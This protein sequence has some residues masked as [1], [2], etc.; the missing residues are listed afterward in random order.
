MKNLLLLKCKRNLLFH[1]SFILLFSLLIIP[2]SN[3][4]DDESDEETEDTQATEVTIPESVVQKGPFVSGSAITI[5]ILDKEFNPTG[6][7]LSVQT[8]ND[9]GEFKVGSKI[10]SN[11]VEVVAK[12]YYFNE[13]SGKLSD[14]ELTLRSVLDLSEAKKMNINVLTSLTKDRIVYLVIEED[15][16]FSKAKKQAEQELLKAFNIPTDNVDSFESM[17][18]SQAGESNAILLALSATL[19]AENSVA[20]LSELISK[21]N[22][23]LEK[24][25]I[26][27]NASTK[28][29]WQVNS[30]LFTQARMA[31]VRSNIA[32]RY[33]NLGLEVSIPNFEDYMD[34]DGD[35]KINKYDTFLSFNISESYISNEVTIGMMPNTTSDT[36]SIDYGSIVLN[37]TDTGQKSISVKQG[38]KVA[39]KISEN[40][41]SDKINITLD[42]N[43]GIINLTWKS[44]TFNGNGNT[45]GSIP[46]IINCIQGSTFTAPGNTG[47]L[48]KA[49]YSFTGWNTSANG[50]GTTYTQGQ[51]FKIGTSGIT[52]YA[53]WASA[54][55]TLITAS[56]GDIGIFMDT[57]NF[58]W[59]EHNPS[60]TFPSYI[61]KAPI[62][63]GIG[64][65]LA[66]G[67]DFVYYVRLIYS[68]KI[69]YTTS[70]TNNIYTIPTIGG[71][72]SSIVTY[73]GIGSVGKMLTDGTYI[74]FQGN[75]SI[76]KTSITGGSYSTL[77]DSGNFSGMVID[78]SNIY[79]FYG[80]SGSGVVAK[81]SKSGGSPT[82]LASGLEQPCSIT[83]DSLYIYWTDVSNIGDM[84]LKKVSKSGGSVTTMASFSREVP[85]IASHLM[86]VQY[87]S[88]YIYFLVRVDNASSSS[89]KRVS[90]ISPYEVSAVVVGISRPAG[91]AIDSSYIYWAS[92]WNWTI[93]KIS[94]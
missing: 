82:I 31:T 86:S 18:I 29:Q 9:L 35:G 59:E 45:S 12:G 75:T 79:Y 91:L 73:T 4:S 23:D 15:M 44:I 6:D 50:S 58:Y 43:S 13:V 26:I 1:F 46:S 64:T 24:D 48:V 94:K 8:K 2:M 68:D 74:Y 30:K 22:L 65:I 52:L 88:S 89:I 66:T 51:T 60:I 87:D 41:G 61:K 55:T 14:G 34:S 36:I 54:W 56:Y 37:G 16:K 17:D 19:Q 72:P 67:T 71:S 77:V 33:S 3:C 84:T 21:I 28:A 53:K 39:I 11:I 90:V 25:G 93:N 49:G 80:S 70:N 81:I 78:S 63:G 47:G 76:N 38:D 62:S 42:N 92:D 85:G 20:Q 7:N 5:Q 69:Y 57:N 10:K 32:T 40:L 27:N 83:N